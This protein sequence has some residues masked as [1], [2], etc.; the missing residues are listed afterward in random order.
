[1]HPLIDVRTSAAAPNESLFARVRE[2]LSC[3]FTMPPR[4]ANSLYD[5]AEAGELAGA[6]QRLGSPRSA[7]VLFTRA[8]T[9]PLASVN[10]R[11]RAA[12]IDLLPL[13]G[14]TIALAMAEPAGR[15]GLCASERKLRL[16][17]D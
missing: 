13:I 9:A 7:A 2:D 16:P 6:V 17:T 4:Q 11:L 12:L 15:N 1:M 5:A 14:V 3:S 10:Q 8:R